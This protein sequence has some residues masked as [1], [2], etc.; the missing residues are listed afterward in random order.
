MISLKSRYAPRLI[1]GKECDTIEI[2][3]FGFDLAMPQSS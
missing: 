1:C 3:V 2:L